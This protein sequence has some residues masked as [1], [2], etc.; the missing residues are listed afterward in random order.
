MIVPPVEVSHQDSKSTGAKVYITFGWIT[1][2]DMNSI[3]RAEGMPE[4]AEGWEHVETRLRDLA[5]NMR[6]CDM[7]VNS[8]LV[9]ASEITLRAKYASVAAFEAARASRE[10]NRVHFIMPRPKPSPIQKPPPTEQ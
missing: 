6:A 5:F 8:A 3:V 10:G 7:P 9:K 4:P 1:L 2:T